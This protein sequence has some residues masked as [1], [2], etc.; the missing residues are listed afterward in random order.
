MEQRKLG[1]LIC[2]SKCHDIHQNDKSRM[3]LNRTEQNYERVD[4]FGSKH[5]MK[6]SDLAF[7]IRISKCR[8]TQPYDTTQNNTQQ[9][10]EGCAA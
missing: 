9:N 8:N 6:H 2:N 4:P 5:Q 10:D 1:L 3:I 7:L